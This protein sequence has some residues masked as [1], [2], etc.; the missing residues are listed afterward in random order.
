M[1]KR[2]SNTDVFLLVFGNFQE[3]PFY[4]TPVVAASVDKTMRIA[5]FLQSLCSAT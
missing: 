3:Q 4:R 5:S 2:D 1:L